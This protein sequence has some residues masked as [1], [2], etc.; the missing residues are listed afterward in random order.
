MPEKPRP[1]PTTL[2]EILGATNLGLADQ[3]L[4]RCGIWNYAEVQAFLVERLDVCVTL[5]DAFSPVNEIFGRG[6]NINLQ[7]LVDHDGE[8]DVV[9]NALIQT[10]ETVD[11]AIEK[12]RQFNRQW[13]SNRR[14]IVHHLSFDIDCI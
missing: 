10:P 11:A 8:T 4:K 12:R 13:W 1:N 5:L 7:V 2:S 9:L 6:T 3:V 14:K